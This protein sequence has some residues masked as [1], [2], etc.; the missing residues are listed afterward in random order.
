ME[1]YV[2]FE[3]LEKQVVNDMFV[4]FFDVWLDYE[5]VMWKLE[6]VLDGYEFME[7]VFLFFVLMGNFCF[8][9]CNLVF[10]DFVEFWDQFVYLGVFIVS[11]F[12]IKDGFQFLFVLGLG[13]FGL[14]NVFLCFVLFKYFIKEVVKYVLNVIF[15]SNLCWIWFYV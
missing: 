1:E 12:C 10:Y 14:L 4:V 5:E 2:C 7:V 11:Y 3:K 6:E 8:Y 15:G 13:D 9:F